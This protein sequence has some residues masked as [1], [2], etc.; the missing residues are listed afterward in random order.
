M[1]SCRWTQTEVRED[2]RGPLG[3]RTAQEIVQR[4]CG[5]Q[6]SGQWGT[7]QTQRLPCCCRENAENMYYFSELALTLNEHEDGVAPTDSR[8]RPDQRLMERGR[9]DEAN[10][11]KQRLEEKQRV[12]RRRRMETCAASCSGEDGEAGCRGRGRGARDR[13]GQG[14]RERCP[15]GGCRGG[16]EPAAHSPAPHSCREGDR[17]LCATVV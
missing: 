10:T 2:S 16:E 13:A 15:G 6:L 11:E 5:G 4:Q 1:E 14:E 17:P 3:P 7:A 8:L 9:W 12:S